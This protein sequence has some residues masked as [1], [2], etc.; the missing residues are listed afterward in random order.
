MANAQQVTYGVNIMNKWLL[1]AA[2][3]VAV[4]ASPAS[5]AIQV[6]VENVGSIL[7][8]SLALPAEDTPGSSIGFAQYFEFSLPVSEVV[9]MSV[10]DSGLGNEKIVGGVFSVN[11]D[12]TT[13]PGPLFIPSGALIDS[14]ALS[15]FV[16]GQEAVVGPNTLAAGNY[17]AEVSGISGASALHL[18]ID[19]TVTATTVV[20]AVATPE[21][22]TW[23][24]FGIGVGFLAFVGR[25]RKQV[26][27]LINFA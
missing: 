6:N 19:G 25:K 27:R 11:F 23:A 26:E 15:N 3:L 10:S 9:T 12:T 24:M 7:N 18:A 5:A 14:A 4:G 1:G 21:P 2:F 20:G 17:F 16:G 8:E 22:S 13:G